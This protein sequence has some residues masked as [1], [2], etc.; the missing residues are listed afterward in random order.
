MAPRI[1][2]TIWLPDEIVTEFSGRAEL[3]F[4]RPPVTGVFSRSETLE[5]LPDYDG[6]LIHG[7]KFDAGDIDRGLTGKLKVIGRHGVG[8]DS[9][10]CDYAG[11]KG[12]PVVNTPNAVTEPTAELTIAIMLSAARGVVTLDRKTRE[13]GRCGSIFSFDGACVGV[14]G[15]TLGI[16]GFGRIGKAVAAKAAGLGMKI[17]YSDPV[18]AP[19]EV[20]A[21]SGATRVELKDLFGMADVVTL[22][23]P[24]VPENLHII[25]ET[26]L[27]SM[28][29]SAIL[30]NASRGKMVDEAALARALA[31]KAIRGAALDVYEFEPEI[32]ASLL[33]MDNV[34][35][36]PHVG[37]Y[38]YEARLEMARE[39]LSG[40]LAYLRGETPPNIFNAAALAGR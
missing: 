24:F 29:P 8:C 25:N 20:E 2:S 21:K 31:A 27:A 4:P 5:R 17:V 18:A 11:A 14:Y 32:T 13:A 23:C 33:A 22:H 26:S 10:D 16:I 37:T 1:L 6:V 36:V 39:A 28:K 12:L 19:K 38:T 9:V 30:V 40:M 15:K 7:E 34:V 3:D 35:L